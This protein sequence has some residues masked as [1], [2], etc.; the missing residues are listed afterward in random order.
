MAHDIRIITETELRRGLFLDLASI[1]VIE[2][3]F[4]ALARGIVTMPPIVSMELHSRNAEVGAKMAFIEGFDISALKVSTGFYDNPARG[5]PSL[6]GM[7]TAMSAHDGRV[8]VVFLDNG[9]LTDLRTAAAGAVAARHLAPPQVTPAVVNTTPA[10]APLIQPE[11]LHPGLHI[12]A[13]GA[14]VP[15]KT[16]IAP[17]CLDA[18][19]LCVAD[20][21]A[22][23]ALRSELRAARAAGLWS[24]TDPTELGA[25]VTGQIPERR[26]ADE[27]TIADLTGTGAQD[28]AIAA[29]ALAA[30]PHAGQ[31][32][33]T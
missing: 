9:Y 16:E 10:T 3:A 24:E 23:V 19:D 26:S 11:H 28:T 15:E 25:I 27:I 12:T 13:T 22:Q 21:A 33:T 2:Q 31:K 8:A 1:D 18:A 4:A 32:I 29:H 20:S 17:A 30:F 14:A 6:G 7:V 5:I